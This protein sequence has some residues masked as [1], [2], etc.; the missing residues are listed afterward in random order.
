LRRV[1]AKYKGL[2]RYTL[3]SGLHIGFELRFK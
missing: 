1:Q 3:D 2:G